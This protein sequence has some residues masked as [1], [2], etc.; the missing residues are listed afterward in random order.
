MY[1]VRKNK[2]KE[3]KNL[4]GVGD[5]RVIQREREMKSHRDP[6]PT[7]VVKLQGTLG[8]K[9]PLPKVI[10]KV[11]RLTIPDTYTHKKAKCLM[12]LPGPTSKTLFPPI[13]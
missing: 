10:G 8:S 4:G 12:E 7:T 3:E 5:A 13:Y 1:D 2:K 6:G 9:A 11:L